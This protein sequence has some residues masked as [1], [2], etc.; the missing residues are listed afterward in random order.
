MSFFIGI[1]LVEITRINSIIQK[2]GKAFLNKIYT[3]SEQNYCDSNVNPSIHYAGRFAAKEAVKKALMSSG[4]HN[5]IPLKSIEVQRKKNGEPFISKVFQ[6]GWLL[7][8]SISHTNNY[9]TAFAIYYR[10]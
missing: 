10:A 9:A 8:V 1:D 4:I 2:S 7:K 6:Y 5:A 3:K